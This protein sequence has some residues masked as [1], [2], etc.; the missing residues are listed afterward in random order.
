MK[1]F[2]QEAIAGS[3]ADF[4][5]IRLEDSF[6]TEIGFSGRDLRK[7]QETRDYGGYVR[8]LIDGSWG[9][10]S[11]NEPEKLPDFVRQ[12]ELKARSAGRGNVVLAP[13][14][15]V[16]D[17][18]PISADPDDDL[19]K[20]P[21][22]EKI[23]TL[24]DLAERILSYSNQ[25]VSCNVS[26]REENRHVLFGTSE[27]T[28]IDMHGL[29]GAGGMGA[30][31]REGNVV[32]SVFSGFGTRTRWSEIL[33]AHSRVEPI[34]SEVVDL[35]RA[36]SVAGGRYT[37]VLDPR[38]SGVF[39]HEA[40][41]H[42][43]EADNVSDNPKLLSQMQLGT[44]FA[45]DHFNVLDGGSLPDE[46]GTL[47][48]DDEGVPTSLTYLI[49]DGLLTGRLHSRSTAA[50]MGENP[51][52][53]AR[54]VG[55][56]F[57]PICRMTNTYIDAGPHSF[58]QMLEGIGNGLYVV[59]GG[60][61]NTS[62][63]LFTFSAEKARKIQNGKIGPWVRDLVLTGNVFQTLRDIDMV[64]N[65]LYRSR[66]G[67]CGKS[68]GARMQYPLCVSMGSPHVRIQNVLIGGR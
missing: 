11:F 1:A 48:Y 21:L 14:P 13:V 66:S 57:A 2:L 43:S 4:V 7:A 62:K 8:A 42:L 15:V 40:F 56:R 20:V 64:G 65:D 23:R 12:A 5:E 46:R 24:A 39:I 44:R 58:E 33:G 53:N 31:A 34:C 47:P 9:F 61:G 25:I 41:G 28:L 67:G 18:V 10:V 16:Q 60:S 30:I 6:R 17:M 51:T 54:T 68:V 49:K 59:G 29:W 52:G 45:Q 35:V 36:E 26:Y 19:R 32:Q 37:V 38:L 63:G 22:D 27:G 55:Y 3:N 50:A